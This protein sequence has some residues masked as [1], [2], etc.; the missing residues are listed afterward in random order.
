MLPERVLQ[1]DRGITNSR[2]RAITLTLIKHGTR[3]LPI[4]IR[5]TIATG[6]RPDRPALPV[7]L[8]AS[9]YA[10]G[11]ASRTKHTLIPMRF[12]SSKIWETLLVRSVSPI[13]LL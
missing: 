10:L 2:K 12:Q 4:I 6:E 11:G 13:L 1:S 3:L 7:G 5:V 9:K 8:E